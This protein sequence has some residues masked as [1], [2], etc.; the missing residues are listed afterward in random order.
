MFGKKCPNCDKKIQKDFIFCPYCA[1]PVKKNEEKDNF[2]MLG[3]EDSTAPASILNSPA[4]QLGGIDRILHSLM[5]QLG[6]E[7]G[8]LNG[9]PGRN[10]KIQISTGIPQNLAIAK[11]PKKSVS[12]TEKFS[13][14]EI[15]IE[16]IERRKSL[17]RREAE[18]NVRRFSDRVVYEIKVP[19]V[20]KKDQILINQLDNCFEVRAYSD[21]LCY[22]KSIPIDADLIQSYLKED[23]L[24]LELK[25]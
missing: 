18:S 20:D 10:F 4:G 21:K 2:G 11:K 22:T 23:V 19:G 7:L 8:N 13:K 6:K 14:V 16:E 1:F 5:N 25:E 12:R 3:K 24:V 15:P 17:P 9:M